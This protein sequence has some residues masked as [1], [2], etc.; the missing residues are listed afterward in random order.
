VQ[1]SFPQASLLSSRRVT[2]LPFS[3][4]INDRL[5]VNNTLATSTQTFVIEVV[6]V[7][8]VGGVRI[9]AF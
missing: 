6:T 1:L 9:M 7:G 5:L 8:G 2:L 3:T 4:Y